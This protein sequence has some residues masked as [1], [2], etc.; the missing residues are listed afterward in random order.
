MMDCIL[1]FD[2]ARERIMEKGAHALLYV[3]YLRENE[4]LLY[5]F[6]VVFAL[7]CVQVS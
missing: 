2:L 6:L 3:F 5:L 7:V 4:Y 1:L